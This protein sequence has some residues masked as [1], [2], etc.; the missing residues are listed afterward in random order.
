MSFRI[1]KLCPSPG[2]F[3]QATLPTSLNKRDTF[4]VLLRQIACSLWEYPQ[5]LLLGPFFFFFLILSKDDPENRNR[6]EELL[7]DHDSSKPS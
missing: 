6:T 3:K 4:V 7:C 5:K 2:K 1:R